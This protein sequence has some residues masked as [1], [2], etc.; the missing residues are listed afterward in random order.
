MKYKNHHWKPELKTFPPSHYPWTAETSLFN[1][2]YEHQEFQQHKDFELYR[3]K[4]LLA[5]HMPFHSEVLKKVQSKNLVRFLTTIYRDPNDSLLDQLSEQLFAY[6]VERGGNKPGAI[7]LGR[8]HLKRMGTDPRDA[9]RIIHDLNELLKPVVALTFE[10]SNKKRNFI[11]L[12]IVPYIPN[13][14]CSV[15]MLHPKKIA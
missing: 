15:E 7:I 3:S 1:A 9:R 14:E 11:N 13:T 4:M 8:E 5:F 10:V 6:H 12:R 2:C